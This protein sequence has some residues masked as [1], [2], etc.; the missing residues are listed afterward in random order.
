MGVHTLSDRGH[1]VKNL[2]SE[3]F[4]DF[5]PN[6]MWKRS[7]VV[8]LVCTANEQPAPDHMGEDSGHFLFK[9]LLLTIFHAAIHHQ[10]YR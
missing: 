4:S 2:R 8:C 3:S 7:D 6:L 5:G 9:G 10:S 1:T